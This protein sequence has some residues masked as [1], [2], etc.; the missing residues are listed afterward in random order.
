[1]I[2]SWNPT[3]N[4]KAY[5]TFEARA[6]YAGGSTKY[7]TLGMW[8]TNPDAHPRK[9]LGHQKDDD[10][11]VA[12]DVLMLRRPT[13]QLQLRILVGGEIQARAALKFV[14]ICL[15]DTNAALQP[16]PPLKAA[17]GKLVPVP[18]RT[19]MVYPDGKSLCSPT[20]VSMLL[21]YWAQ[22]LKQPDL[23]SPVP[24]IVQAIY[25]SQWQGT[26]NWPFNTAYAGS[27]PGMRAY[28]SR[29][30]DVSE[31]ETWIARGF[32][33]GLS[34]DYDR[35]RAKGPGPN[36]HIVAC[37][38]FTS[39]G[40]PVINDPGTSQHVRK[41][42]PRKNLIYAWASSGNTVYLIYPEKMA[43]PDDLFGHWDSPKSRAIR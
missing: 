22:A 25:D 23:D 26:G 35:L 39:N 13:D 20:S 18:E 5:F 10:G 19:Q 7:Y 34:V 14:G 33:V 12:T 29:L 3:T 9:S 6:L 37:V 16:L 1:M 2:V 4:S 38:G 11:D 41:V 30:S 43:P 15:S 21:G 28:V 27:L 36:G 31:L 8:S 24:V 40:D 17:W 32:P 42:F